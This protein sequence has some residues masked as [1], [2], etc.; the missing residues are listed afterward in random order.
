[1]SSLHICAFNVTWE[2]TSSSS[3]ESPRAQNTLMNLFLHVLSV[4]SVVCLAAKANLRG[5]CVSGGDD[6]G[7]TDDYTCIWTSALSQAHTHYSH[8][9]AVAMETFHFSSLCV[10]PAIRGLSHLLQHC[11]WSLSGQ[12]N[13]LNTRRPQKY[14]IQLNNS[15][16]TYRWRETQAD[17]GREHERFKQTVS[18][19]KKR[20]N[21]IP[22]TL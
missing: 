4:C 2:R 17:I 21:H 5:Y 12:H 22:E 19:N 6:N 9:T 14:D 3:S 20:L 8:F 10:K 13:A 15:C 11:P 16:S 18:N 7:G 1:M